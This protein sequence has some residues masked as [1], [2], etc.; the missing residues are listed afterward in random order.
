MKGLIMIDGR[1]VRSRVIQ[2]VQYFHHESDYYSESA[3]CPALYM[4]DPRGT[5]DKEKE[6]WT[7]LTDEQSNVYWA[8]C[9][10]GLKEVI[11]GL[12]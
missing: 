9:D 6:V 11:E 7:P 4:G 1:V 3:D 8:K 5:Y 12:I 2:V 10:C